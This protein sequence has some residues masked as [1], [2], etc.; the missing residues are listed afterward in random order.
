MEIGEVHNNDLEELIS[1][2]A[3]LK[4]GTLKPGISRILPANVGQHA[5]G[6]KKYPQFHR[7]A[8]LTSKGTG[9]VEEKCRRIPA[10]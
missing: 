7:R 6:V 3:R 2:G 4:Q 10:F 5:R 8:R 9:V 1:F